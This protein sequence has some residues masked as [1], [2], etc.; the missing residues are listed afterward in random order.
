MYIKTLTNNVHTDTHIYVSDD[1]T[2]LHTVHKTSQ[3]SILLHVFYT[4]RAL[5]SA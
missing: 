3:L 2:Q 5:S 4:C 1:T